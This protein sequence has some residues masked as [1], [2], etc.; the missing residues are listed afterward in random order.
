MQTVTLTVRCVIL[1]QLRGAEALSANDWVTEQTIA[2]LRREMEADEREYE[3]RLAQARKREEQLRRKAAGRMN[4]KMRHSNIAGAS[5]V[6]EEEE[7][8][9]VYLPEDDEDGVHISPELRM[10]MD[11][12][13]VTATG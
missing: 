1:R 5:K 3:E 13:V 9:R 8:D 11:K 2:R 12:Y 10:L 7:D 6:A 4:K